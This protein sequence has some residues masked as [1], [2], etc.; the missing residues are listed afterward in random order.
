MIFLVAGNKQ[1]QAYFLDG[2]ER[3]RFSGTISSF[4]GAAC[5]GATRGGPQESGG[6]CKV[7]QAK[8][9]L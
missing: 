7:I 3:A 1:N 2:L 5:P 4:R 8:K 6:D 9:N